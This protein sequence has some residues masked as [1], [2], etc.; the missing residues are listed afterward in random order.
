M[1]EITLTDTE[2]L[3]EMTQIMLLIVL[4]DG[5]TIAGAKDMAKRALTE[6]VNKDCIADAMFVLTDILEDAKISEDGE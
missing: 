6:V 2:A 5:L 4:T 1:K 3:L